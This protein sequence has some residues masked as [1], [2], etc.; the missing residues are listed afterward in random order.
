LSFLQQKYNFTPITIIRTL[1]YERE[2]GS[3]IAN[4][5]HK[6]NDPKPNTH[7]TLPLCTHIWRR[8]YS[9][10]PL[11]VTNQNPPAHFTQLVRNRLPL[12]HNR[13]CWDAVS[14]SSTL[15]S[16][17]NRYLKTKCELG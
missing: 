14:H 15:R 10:H 12:L 1:N 6:E 9:L 17:E 8:P 13:L 4:V 7:K 16:V 5:W 3:A 2:R 11:S